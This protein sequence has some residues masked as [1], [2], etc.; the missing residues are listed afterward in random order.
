MIHTSSE[1]QTKKVLFL[2]DEMLKPQPDNNPWKLKHFGFVPSS[3]GGDCSLLIL[4][5]VD[6]TGQ[7]I[8]YTTHRDGSHSYNNLGTL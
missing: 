3:E 1:A 6:K 4:I 5:F 2:L 8:Y 7:M